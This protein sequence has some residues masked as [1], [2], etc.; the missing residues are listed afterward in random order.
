MTDILTRAPEAKMADS[1]PSSLD[2][3]EAFDDFM[4][5]FEAFKETNDERLAQIESRVGADVVTTEK[6]ERINKALDE[7]ALKSRRLPIGGDAPARPSE[8]KQA[9]EAY[10]RRGDETR[11]RRLQEKSMTAGTGSEGG[12]LV[13]PETEIE[14]GRR[15]AQVSPIRAIASVRQISA[16][17]YKKPFAVSGPAV[18]WVGETDARPETTAPTLAELEFPAMELYAMPAATQTLLD[19]TAVDIDAWIAQEVETAFAEQE[20]TAFVTGDGNK[21]P[22]GFLDYTQVA[23]ASWSWGNVGYLATGVD[24][25]FA[26]T[27]P[28]D[29]L[30]DLVFALKAGYRGNAHFVMNRKTQGE[31]RK[32]KDA[33]GNYLWQP[34]HQAGVPPTLMGFPV[35]EA[36]DMP[37][38]G[39]AATPIAFGDFQ[40]GYLVVDRIGTRILRD[41]YSAKP[42]VLFYTTRRVGGGVQD[43]GAIKL[44]K[45]S[46]S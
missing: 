20:G 33:D 4:Q 18:G 13:A 21:K 12:Y 28:A 9:F 14:I 32:I 37:D 42:Y 7:L 16:T 26:A 38:I 19:D 44:L 3:V 40:R 29:K 17:T 39:S 8:A 34:G 11:M 15:L 25:D 24:G 6:M 22:T 43:F 27:D 30:V 46:V 45:F 41:P 5:A 23:E 35:A 1:A 31:V 2:V 10:V 36:E